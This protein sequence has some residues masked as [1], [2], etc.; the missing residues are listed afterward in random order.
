RAIATARRYRRFCVI[1]VRKFPWCEH[2]LRATLVP[3]GVDQA[4]NPAVIFL[5]VTLKPEAPAVGCANAIAELEG[6]ARAARSFFNDVES[7]RHARPCAGHPRLESRV[8][9]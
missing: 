6:C 3:S 9:S 2:G 4:A 7:L 8:G 1:T 5:A